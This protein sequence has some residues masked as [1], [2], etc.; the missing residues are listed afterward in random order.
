MLPKYTKLHMLTPTSPYI[1]L[2]C[3]SGKNHRLITDLYIERLVFK[4]LVITLLFEVV[5]LHVNLSCQIIIIYAQRFSSEIATTKHLAMEC[6]NSQV[7]NG[8]TTF[9]LTSIQLA[10]ISLRLTI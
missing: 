3:F 8:R 4:I 7:G 2:K 10:T 5:F 6:A 1:T 9:K